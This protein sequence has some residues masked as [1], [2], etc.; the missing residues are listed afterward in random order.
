MFG[1]HILNGIEAEESVLLD[2]SFENMDRKTFA[3]FIKSYI[4]F[5]QRKFT[6]RFTFKLNYV[7]SELTLAFGALGILFYYAGY[8]SSELRSILV[9]LM[10][11]SFSISLP[12]TPFVYIYGKR[13][14]NL[15][16]TW[17]EQ[18]EPEEI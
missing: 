4:S 13:Y 2:G 17:T 7:F 14:I 15:K 12:S 3:K 11:L 9:V 8:E 10:T 16:K 6:A 1:R 5:E 18:T